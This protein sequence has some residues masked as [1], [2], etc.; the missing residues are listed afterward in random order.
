VEV[1]W[2]LSGIRDATSAMITIENNGEKKTI[3]LIRSGQLSGSYADPLLTADSLVTLDVQRGSGARIRR[4]APMI[5]GGSAVASLVESPATLPPGSAM[6]TTGTL[7]SSAGDPLR[8]GP[9]AP[10]PATET[11]ER[12]MAGPLGITKPLTAPGAPRPSAVREL[13]SS[14]DLA[15]GAMARSGI[16]GVTLEAVQPRV[17]SRTDSAIQLLAPLAGTA[18]ASPLAG[19][20]PIAELPQLTASAPASSSTPQPP[21]ALPSRTVAPEPAV[22]AVAAPL[23]QPL[24][25]TAMPTPAPSKPAVAAAKPAPPA[26]RA[27]RAIWTGQL[28]KNQI[29]QVNGSDANQGALNAALPGQPVRLSVLPGELTSQGLVVYTANPRYRDAANAVEEPGPTNGWNRTRYRYDPL[30]AN[31]IIVTAIPNQTNRWQGITVRND[32][33][34]VDVIVIDWLAESGN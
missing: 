16:S 17:P 27:G 13:E 15:R 33:K 8:D 23:N 31:S 1:V 29:L 34:T 22:R 18:E 19:A 24:A 26:A 7:D 12:N 32:G 11:S 4:V 14:S 30:R 25:P 10:P 20:A 21:P 28:R 3:D 5:D 2:Q 9:A 6:D